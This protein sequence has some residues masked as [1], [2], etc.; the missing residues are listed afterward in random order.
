MS[1]VSQQ[2]CSIYMWSRPDVLNHCSNDVIPMALSVE[3]LK[4]TN[5]L[6][7]NNLVLM[8]HC[9]HNKTPQNRRKEVSIDITQVVVSVAY[10]CVQKIE[11]TKCSNL[12]VN[13]GV[14]RLLTMW[15]MI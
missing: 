12:L 1:D 2:I 10:P 3:A 14:A 4:S 5:A 8:P 13:T 9:G 15:A 11:T 6:I 7:Y